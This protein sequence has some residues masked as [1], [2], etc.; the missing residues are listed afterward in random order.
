LCQTVIGIQFVLLV[1]YFCQK[2]E[3]VKTEDHY[4][5]F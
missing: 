5:I 4:Y 1:Q 2:C 3:V